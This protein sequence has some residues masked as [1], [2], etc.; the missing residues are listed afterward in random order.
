MLEVIKIDKKESETTFN[1]GL[2]FR[3]IPSYCKNVFQDQI[4]PKTSKM[5]GRHSDK[6]QHCLIN[7]GLCKCVLNENLVYLSMFSTHILH[8]CG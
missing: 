5:K 6:N 7:D 8:T 1:L 2:Y 3:L 4:T